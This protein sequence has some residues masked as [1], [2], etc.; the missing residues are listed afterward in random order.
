MAVERQTSFKIDANVTAAAAGS[1]PVRMTTYAVAQTA[2][3]ALST[4]SSGL[5]S[6]EAG[7]T[8]DITSIVAQGDA[9]VNVS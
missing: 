4:A 6:L 7:S 8:V 3:V 1:K 9:W 5:G 2:E